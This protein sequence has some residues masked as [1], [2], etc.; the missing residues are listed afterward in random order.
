MRGGR[1]GKGEKEGGKG[2]IAKRRRIDCISSY[3]RYVLNQDNLHGIDQS[4]HLVGSKYTPP[5]GSASD[6]F[7]WPREAESHKNMR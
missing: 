2:D 1:E 4:I 6:F 3:C 5:A 7:L